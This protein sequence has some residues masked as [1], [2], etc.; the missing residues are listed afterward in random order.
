MLT[1]DLIARGVDIPD[2]DLILQYDAPQDPS[3][4]I[5]RVGRTARAGKTGIALLFLHPNEE[6]YVDYLKVKQVP[7]SEMK[8]HI[9]HSELLERVKKMAIEDRDVMEKGQNAFVSFI[10]AYK[11]H[12]CNLIFRL[13]QLDLGKVAT[14]MGLLFVCILDIESQI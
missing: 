2:V 1:T 12:Q 5:H 14:G 8:L 3:F 4:Y 11:E 7:V 9:E 10:R 13:P 6:S